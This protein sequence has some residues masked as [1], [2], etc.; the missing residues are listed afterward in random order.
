MR[1]SQ[2]ARQFQAV[3]TRHVEVEQGN[4]EFGIDGQR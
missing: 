2:L 4:V 3:T 1:L